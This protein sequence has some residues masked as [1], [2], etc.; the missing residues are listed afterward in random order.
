LEPA[1]VGSCRSVGFGAH[2]GSAPAVYT[3]SV[4]VEPGFRSQQ[5]ANQ[6]IHSVRLER[7]VLRKG[8][9]IILDIVYETESISLRIEGLNRAA[10]SSDL[11]D[12]HY[13]PCLTRS[14]TKA[15]STES[16]LLDITGVVLSRIQ[17]RIPEKAI[18]WRN[19]RGQSSTVHL[20][21]GLKRGERL[22]NALEEM[23]KAKH[24]PVLTLNGHCQVCEFQGRCRAQAI[25]EDNLS[26]LRGI[27]EAEVNR[28]RRR[29]IFT[30]NQLSYTFR[31]R[32][33]K[34]RAKNPAHPHY[35]ALQ[36]RALRERKVFVHG[37]PKLGVE[38]PGYL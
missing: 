8:A 23:Q 25:E 2:S 6:V 38:G 28:L 9:N 14:R 13:Q 24:P 15:F 16:A 27:S 10:G 18:V 3:D 11:G 20:S 36:A 7:S 21:P 33:I 32:R 4:S 22:L 37:T 29:G 30:I 26:L 19:P 1:Q 35:F 31:P 12:F 34:K 5:T 17:G